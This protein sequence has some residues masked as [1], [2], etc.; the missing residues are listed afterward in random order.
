LRQLGRADLA[1]ARRRSEDFWAR[2]G[3]AHGDEVERAAVDLVGLELRVGDEIVCRVANRWAASLQA[4]LDVE[5]EREAAWHD[6][7]SSRMGDEP[8]L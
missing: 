7:V 8:Q 5:R 6:R 4:S 2:E 1:S 3:R